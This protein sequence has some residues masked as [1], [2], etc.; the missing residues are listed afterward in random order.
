MKC[1]KC[2]KI[3]S[4]SDKFCTYCGIQMKKED[5]SLEELNVQY[6]NIKDDL[7]DIKEKI[8]ILSGSKSKN[9]YPNSVI[10]SMSIDKEQ[11]IFRLPNLEEYLG[12]NWLVRIGVFALILGV[13][14]FLQHAFSNNWI[15]HQSQIATGILISFVLIF[16][17]DFFSKKYPIYS[18]ALSGGG[19]AILYLTVFI[20]SSIY[21]IIKPSWVSMFMLILTSSISVR[22]AFLRNSQTLA[23]LGLIGALLAPLLIYDSEISREVSGITFAEPQDSS[24]LVYY[25]FVINL[26]A[27]VI[28]LF[29]DWRFFKVLSILGS[30]QLLGTWNELY[31]DNIS[32]I[33]SISF[34]T[35]NFLMQFLITIGYFVRKNVIPNIWEYSTISLNPLIFIII[36][37]D[38]LQSDNSSWLG[39]IIISVGLLYFIFAYISY[40]RS[41][42]EITLS[43]MLAGVGLICIFSAIPVQLSGSIVTILF[44]IQALVF[45]WLSIKFKSW[46]FQVFSSGIFVVVIFRLLFTDFGN[47]ELVNYQIVFN[48]RFLV[49]F[50]VT[51]CLSTSSYFYFLE[52]KKNEKKLYTRN[53][54][55]KITNKNLQSIRQNLSIRNLFIFTILATNFFIVWSISFEITSVFD[56]NIF[57]LDSDTKSYAKG[58]GLTIFWSIYSVILLVIGI[59]KRS[60]QIRSGAIF[61]LAIPVVKLFVYDTFNLEQIYRITSYVFL[62]VLL[63]IGGFMY[64]KYEDRI[65]EFILK[66]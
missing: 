32:I 44:S 6:R 29:K 31:K 23:I 53:L 22:L 47:F 8:S 18:F 4:N 9:K 40:I 17:G 24:L 11:K 65:K 26:F 3:V 51:L 58:L 39:S 46:E 5:L 16:F 57:D 27:L 30:Y 66:D 45:V 37:N 34:L 49:F 52:M 36:S 43:S 63:I 14:F 61:L 2:N 13:G 21:E 62:G 38:L 19:I 60:Y 50:V 56:S 55:F 54:F 41:N 25:L 12:G 1:N 28:S 20:G 48:E 64:Q 15:N 59:S 7:R 33:N 35:I 10:S 42:Y